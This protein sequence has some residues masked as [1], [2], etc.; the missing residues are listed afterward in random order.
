VSDTQRL[1]V[2]LDIACLF[3]TRTEAKRACEGGKIRVNDQRAKPNR[4]LRAG[5]RLRISRSFGRAQDVVVKALV[6]QH[7]RKTDARI[8]YNDVTPPLSAED[9]EARRLERT[10]RAAARAT[11]TPDHRQRRTL[12]RLKEGA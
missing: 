1:D 12:R 8:L 2:W 11:G 5:D 7:I 9:I 3:R 4:D 10:Y 6:A